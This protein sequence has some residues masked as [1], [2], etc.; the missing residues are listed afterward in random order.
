MTTKLEKIEMNSIET[1]YF[2]ELKEQTN[3]LI[4]DID[5]ELEVLESNMNLI[6]S[7]QGYR[8]NEVTKTLTIFSVIFIP[9]TF[10]AGIYGM[11]FKNIPEL[12]TD[13]GYFV[14]LGIMVLIT[15]VTV[16]YFT[17]K[18]WF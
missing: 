5:F 2:T 16:R 12:Q 15:G 7:I 18:K 8:L 6:F 17:K 1:K 9:L 10:L 3:H 13:N 14:L 4:S 11:N